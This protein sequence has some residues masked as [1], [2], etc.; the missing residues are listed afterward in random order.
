[1]NSDR[2]GRQR[3]RGYIDEKLG[4]GEGA[5]STAVKMKMALIRE[6]RAES[7][8]ESLTYT[9]SRDLHGRRRDVSRQQNVEEAS[10]R[11]D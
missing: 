4:G 10:V 9:N 1:M 3:Q 6:R 5:P 2:L 11:F 7:G 8:R